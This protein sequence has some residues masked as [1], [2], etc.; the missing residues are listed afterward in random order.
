[1]HHPVEDYGMKGSARGV[2]GF[3]GGDRS[4]QAELGMRRQHIFATIRRRGAEVHVLVPLR[5]AEWNALVQ[6]ILAEAL[7]RGVHYANQ[8]VI[9]AMLFIEQRRR[10]FGIET[11]GC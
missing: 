6:L 5:D 1:M 7:G 4:S 9:V 8:F 3:L 10:M 11:E 2:A